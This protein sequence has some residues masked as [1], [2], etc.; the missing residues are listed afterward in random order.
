MHFFFI[1]LFDRLEPRIKLK[2]F[3]VTQKL[4]PLCARESL[5]RPFSNLEF[6]LDYFLFRNPL[7][8][9]CQLHLTNENQLR[10]QKIHMHACNSV[11]VFRKKDFPVVPMSSDSYTYLPI[12][13]IL[14][15]IMFML[16]ISS[17]LPFI[18][19]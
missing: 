7:R 9:T 10:H 13:K 17:C 15:D 1:I 19:H 8:L 18:N 2:R 12:M 16:C 3:R 4:G 14:S 5:V 6:L 11:K